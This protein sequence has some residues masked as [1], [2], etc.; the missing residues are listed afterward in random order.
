[1]EVLE[2]RDVIKETVKKYFENNK[3]YDNALL[4]ASGSEQRHI[5]EMGTSIL[6]TKWEVG[7]PG[8]SFVQAVVENDLAKAISTADNTN[9]KALKFYSQLIYNVG[10]PIELLNK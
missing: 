4:Y 10:M 9:I 3:E 5:I 8:G 6:C 2:K 7:F 1:M